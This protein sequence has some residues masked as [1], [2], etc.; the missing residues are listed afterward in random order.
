MLIRKWLPA[1][2]FLMCFAFILASSAHAEENDLFDTRETVFK[3]NDPN[4]LINGKKVVLQVPPTTINNYTFVPLR[5]VSDAI[6]ANLTRKSD[7]IRLSYEGVTVEITVGRAEAFVQSNP[8]R[9]EQPPVVIKGTTMVPLR[10]IVN[11][12]GLDL[13][14]EPSTKEI[15]ISSKIKKTPEPIDEDQP[16][17]K[18]DVEEEAPVVRPRMENLTLDYLSANHSNLKSLD[19]IR[20]YSFGNTSI[21][22]AK[23]NQVYILN[24][25][26]NKGYQIKKYDPNSADKMSVVASID[27]RFN[28]EYSVRDKYKINFSYGEFVPK[29]LV[30]NDA[31]DTLYLL[32]ESAAMYPDKLRLAVFSITPEVKMVTYQ[33]ENS[34]F[35]KL[36]DSFFSTLDDK[37]FYYGEPYSKMIYSANRGQALE[38]VNSSPTSDK[39]QLI[40]TVKD[41]VL[42]VYDKKSSTIF[43]WTGTGLAKHAQVAIHSDSVM[44]VA[45]SF[46]YFYLLD[47]RRVVHRVTSDGKMES[48]AELGKASFN[49]GT[50]G[51]P[52]T[53]NWKLFGNER[54]LLDRYTLHM[55]TDS[56]GNLFLFDD[57]ILMRVNVY[58]S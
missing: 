50:L 32:G 39:T 53:S 19:K 23:D 11:S 35:Y 43:K 54:L 36:E 38:L 52:E 13:R 42:Y 7:E 33:L 27:E 55:S 4:A 17:N 14:Y 57:G 26:P 16:G 2:M 20:L 22:A 37:T 28:F 58:P 41:G 15:R 3:M 30:Y 45:A 29:K 46:G 1:A 31:S 56:N 49:P 34:G 21:A 25:D 47:D 8:V 12:L 6:G 5:S 51:V 40:S 9:L 18:K 48:Y 24:R 44:H 10:F